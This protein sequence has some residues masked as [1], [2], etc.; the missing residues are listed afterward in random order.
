MEEVLGELE[1]SAAAFPGSLPLYKIEKVSVDTF[2]LERAMAAA[3]K[4]RVTFAG[5][6]DKRAKSIQYM[7]PTSAKA[8]R[9]QRIDGDGFTALL[10][11]YV[12]RP[13]V[14]RAS[15]GNTFEIVIRECGLEVK[16]CVE[17]A[18][19][20]GAEMRIPNFFGYQRFGAR[21]AL[22]HMVGRELVGGRFREALNQILLRPRLADGVR[23]REARRLIAEGKYKEGHELLPS[24][25]DIE[26]MVVRRLMTRPDDAVG[27]IRAVPIKLRR[28]YVHAYQ[29]YLFNRTVS[30]ALKRGLDLSRVER[31][32]NWAELSSDGLN[33]NRV[34][35]VR[36]PALEGTVP[37][38]QLAGYAYRNYGSRFDTLLEQVMTE[39][40]VAPR[41]FYV[42]DMQEVSAEGGF[43][44]PHLAMRE[45][46][47]TI[48]ERATKMK[49]T[50]P[51][52]G[53]ATVLLREV[54]KPADPVASGF[55]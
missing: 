37:V 26:R 30:L 45:A 27:A 36:E 44:R 17:E 34:H 53:Y 55:V 20:M 8:R 31:G 40:R 7:T 46:S 10:A 25:Q 52:G 16:S 33:I 11:G 43:R 48:S 9:P 50:L 4:S 19:R 38:V 42:E 39:E 12:D 5:M 51:R 21:E 6:K 47:F 13:I 49:F 1:A 22:T 14:R 32:D 41:D 23:T 29:S 15:S 24:G 28:F 18:Y 2:H 3:L 35:G 54:I